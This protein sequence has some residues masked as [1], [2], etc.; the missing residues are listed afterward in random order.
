MMAET[1]VEYRNNLKYLLEHGHKVMRRG[2]P[3]IEYD[4]MSVYY[5]MSDP[6]VAIPE[7]GLNYAHMFNEA[8][9]ILRGHTSV[10]FLAKYLK[11]MRT[12]S[13]DGMNLSGAYGPCFIAQREYVVQTLGEE[14]LATR[15][16]VI[17][18]WRPSPRPSKD[19]PCTVSM[20]FLVQWIGNVPRL[21]THVYMR[22]S[23]AWLGLPY[24]IFCF[25]MMSLHILLDLVDRHRLPILKLGLLH[26]NMGSF[27]LYEKDVE[28]ARKICDTL[29]NRRYRAISTY[30]S[31]TPAHLE[32]VLEALRDAPEDIFN[33]QP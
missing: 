24:D 5:D 20:Q 29:G 2:M 7:R 28:N 32:N 16:A 26:I 6:I 15:Q 27:H 12:F 33:Y 3:I 13:D 11:K 1:S 10:E 25:S 8:L 17:T 18:F 9:W 21:D 19:I 23:D 22:S 4:G 14:D 31:N 30:G